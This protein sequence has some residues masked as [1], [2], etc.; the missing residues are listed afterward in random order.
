M[1]KVDELPLWKVFKAK[2]PEKLR[3]LVSDRA[4]DAKE[5]LNLVYSTFP[6]YTLHNSTHSANVVR[7]MGKLLGAGVNQVRPLEAALLILSAYFH[8][9]GMVFT[10]DERARLSKQ[11]EFK[12]FLE[13]YPEA[14]LA[15][16]GRQ[17]VPR[18]VAEWYCRW[19]HAERVYLYLNQDE[20]SWDGGSLRDVLGVVCRSHAQ[21]IDALKSDSFET[22]Y[23]GECDLRFC[24]ILLRLADILDFDNSRSPEA[25]YRHLGLAR[26]AE[27][28]RRFKTSDVEWRKHLTARGFKFPGP[29]SRD[30]RYR[31]DFVAFP[32]KPAVDL[33]VRQFLDTIESE[34]DKCAKLLAFC[35]P[36]WQ[37]LPLP[38]RV[39]RSHI[40]S[41]N[42][43]YGD[44]RFTLDQ[45]HILDLL[46]GENLYDSPYVFVRELLQNAIDTSRHREFHERAR[47]Q[48]EYWAAPITVTEWLDADSYRWVRIDDHGMGMNEHLITSYLLKVGRWFYQSSEFQAALLDYQNTI[49]ED[50][51]PISRFGIGLLSCFIAGDRVDISTRHVKE[52]GEVE[53]AIRLHME[54]AH[55][56]YTL[57][58]EE[59]QHE[60]EPMPWEDEANE[61]V[62]RSGYRTTA[63]TSIAVRL[64]PRKEK[65]TL[66]LKEILAQHVLCSPV[67]IKHDGKPVGGDPEALVAK[68]W[69]DTVT[70]SLAPPEIAKIRDLL[71]PNVPDKVELDLIPLDLTKHSPAPYRPPYLQGQ[72]VVGQVKMTTALADVLRDRAFE[73][74][75]LRLELAGDTI[76]LSVYCRIRDTYHLD[77]EISR[78]NERKRAR[79]DFADDAELDYLTQLSANI[80]KKTHGLSGESDQRAYI[81]LTGHLQSVP[82]MLRERLVKLSRQ[83]SSWLA[84]NGIVVPIRFQSRSWTSSLRPAS[85]NDGGWIVALIALGD[86]LRPNV[87]V[88]RDQLHELPWAVHSAAS[89][90]LLRAARVAGLAP[91]SVGTSGMFSALPGKERMLLGDL[92]DDPLLKGPDGWAAEPII[93]TDKGPKSLQQILEICDQQGTV[94]LRSVNYVNE[95]STIDYCSAV[96]LQL[97]TQFDLESKSKYDWPAVV[98]GRVVGP[99]ADGQRF[100]P[101]LFFVPYRG[102]KMLRLN[103]TQPLN[104]DH[105]FSRWLIDNAPE[106]H[107]RYPGILGQLRS[108]AARREYMR[109]EQLK[110]MHAINSLLERVKQLKTSV[111]PPA[112]AFLKERD[113][114]E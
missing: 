109:S 7:L 101:P 111:R 44:F 1:A 46:M 47:G 91:G 112:D 92:M 66:N 107:A 80:K 40:E 64:D 6:T 10:E 52:N 36:R 60:P 11:P 21:N 4:K 74:K 23:R 27:N 67:P 31:L 8:D 114:P 63:G 68:P 99:L 59:K 17:D 48:K 103:Y 104:Q 54:G 72:V 39:D 30:R 96:L 2:A 32:E 50:F 77:L 33:D 53:N 84:H 22:N 105:P 28:D 35:S 71:G 94:S 97:K 24:A 79:P 106:L 95:R 86:T 41:Q 5:V 20:F 87:S 29:E 37:S 58:L 3:I 55:G 9:I 49:Q 16:H 98:R 93:G 15:V 45:H 65:G 61:G 85:P 82:A 69:L 102:L 89:L 100:F 110:A 88:S 78:L 56:F 34:F 42:Y 57:Q 108:E 18:A 26:R 43:K 13:A 38:E 76:Q 113:F 62:Q 19:Q 14:R 51:L 83:E 12:T 73:H 75:S 90:A 81:D 70:I 25:V